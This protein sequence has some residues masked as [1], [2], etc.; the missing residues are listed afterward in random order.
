MISNA[1]WLFRLSLL[2]LAVAATPAAAEIKGL[3][4]DAVAAVTRIEA[5]LNGLTTVQARFVQISTNGTYAEGEII[6]SRPGQMRFDYDPPHPVLLIANGLTLLFYDRELKQATFLPLWR[7]P[8]SFLIR[9]KVRLDDPVEVVAV[10]EALGSLSLTV[11]DTRNEDAGTVT[12][13]FSKQP[14]A[15]KKWSLTDSLGVTTQVSLINPRYGVE[16]DELAFD[17]GGLEIEGGG[18]S[19]GQR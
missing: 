16:I 8:L 6:V 1:F 10:E 13:V 3:S 9:D 19:A 7:T 4:P 18:N 11:R 14:L 12:L 17:H 5:Y 2:L 15:L